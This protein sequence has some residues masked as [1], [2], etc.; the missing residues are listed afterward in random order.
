MIHMCCAGI[1]H[2]LS[3][4]DTGAVGNE[5]DFVLGGTR[6]LDQRV[7]FGMDATELPGTDESHLFGGSLALPL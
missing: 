3:A 4:G 1:Y 2:Q 5:H 6:W 7:D